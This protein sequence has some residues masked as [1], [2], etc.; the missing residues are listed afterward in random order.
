MLSTFIYAA[1]ELRRFS[2]L[3]SGTQHSSPAYFTLLYLG[4]GMEDMGVVLRWLKTLKDT[5]HV[6]V[7]CFDYT[8]FGMNNGL[9]PGPAEE[10]TQTEPVERIVSEKQCYIDAHSAYNHLLRE[11]QIPVDRVVL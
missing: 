11:R 2:Y 7:M 5:L 4:S 8:G 1:T 6:N 9:L 10:E 3:S